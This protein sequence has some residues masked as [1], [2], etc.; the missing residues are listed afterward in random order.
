M[1]N[2]IPIL[3]IVG[4]KGSGKTTII[5]K[6]ISELARRGFK[7]ATAK[8]CGHHTQ[9][10]KEGTDSFKHKAAGAHSSA[11]IAG[12]SLAVFR[13]LDN[14]EEIESFLTKINSDAGIIIIEGDKKSRRPKIEIN[15][16]CCTEGPVCLFDPNL[17]ALITDRDDL[18][19]EV[20]CFQPDDVNGI[21]D[22]IAEKFIKT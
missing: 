14:T 1:S 4:V 2:K 5:V 13:N 21:T 6:I 8:F 9:L 7:V 10:D 17:A 22:F 19:V 12:K 15:R 11:V 18:N 16:K 3:R 20:P